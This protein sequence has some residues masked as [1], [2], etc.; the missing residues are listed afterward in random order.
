M[1]AGIAKTIVRH[2]QLMVAHSQLG[3]PKIMDVPD[4]GA[5]GVTPLWDQMQESDAH[6]AGLRGD[7]RDAAVTS[8]PVRVSG[9]PELGGQVIA[10]DEETGPPGG[11]GFQASGEPKD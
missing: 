1:H 11:Q 2:R 8:E 10:Q 6:R 3:G 9:A 7:R 5:E 4:S